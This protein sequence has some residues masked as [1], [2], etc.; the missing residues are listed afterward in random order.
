[1]LIVPCLIAGFG[2]LK[3]FSVIEVSFVILFMF[4]NILVSAYIIGTITLV[5]VRGDERTREYRDRMKSVQ[6]YTQQHSIPKVVSDLMQEHVELHFRSQE[7]SDERVLAS[8]PSTIRRR[9]LRHL[10]LGQLQRCYLFKG[11]KQ[12]LLDALLAAGRIDLYMPMV[13][14]STGSSLAGFGGGIVCVGLSFRVHWM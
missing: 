11:V 6:E 3:P 1:M 14:D 13:R 7:H 8:L 5:V 9:T 4:F 10:Y 12:K 2:D